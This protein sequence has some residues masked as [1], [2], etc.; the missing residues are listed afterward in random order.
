MRCESPEEERRRARRRDPR[1]SRNCPER[2]ARESLESE[3]RASEEG[4]LRSGVD[5]SLAVPGS[6]SSCSASS[7]A[8]ERKLPHGKPEKG[9]VSELDDD[10]T[11][12]VELEGDSGSSK[13]GSK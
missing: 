3:S 1:E 5:R 12:P 2:P 7:T 10:V 4:R 6:A 8:A 11:T 9:Q 13:T